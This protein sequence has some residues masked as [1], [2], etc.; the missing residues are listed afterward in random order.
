M[1]EKSTSNYRAIRS[2]LIR[3][4]TNLSA[5]A[6]EHGYPVGTTYKAAKGSRN[7]RVATAI[8]RKLEALAR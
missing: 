3:R 4:G 5:W 1:A 2:G 6:R 7:G 8:R